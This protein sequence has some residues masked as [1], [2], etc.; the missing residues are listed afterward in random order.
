MEPPVAAALPPPAVRSA[1]YR[2]SGVLL[3]QYM[4]GVSQLHK[5]VEV[6]EEGG[7]PP[8]W[9]GITYGLQTI[10]LAKCDAIARH[11]ARVLAAHAVAKVIIGLNYH[12]SIANVVAALRVAHPVLVLTGQVKQEAR[13]PLI[14]R[15][16]AS[17]TEHRVLVCN[18]AVMEVGIDLDDK[19]G[20][21]PRTCLYSPHYRATGLHQAIGRVHRTDTRSSATVHIVY[22]PRECAEKSV[23]SALTRKTRILKETLPGQVADGTVFPGD[24]MTLDMDLPGEESKECVGS[25]EDAV[26]TVTKR[27]KPEE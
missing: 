11:A 4:S 14:D 16:Q 25:D 7:E 12:A 24:Y 18:M 1:F 10:E 15:F 13:A 3:E 6:L 20:G 22:G 8:D 26:V 9:R 19:H 27:H 17:N 23:L 5:S 21:F 2:I